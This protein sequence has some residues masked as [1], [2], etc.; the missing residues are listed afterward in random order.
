MDDNI[1]S[2]KRTN[3]NRQINVSDWSMFKAME[4]FCDR[5]TNVAMAWPNY[6]MFI[7]RKQKHPP[8]ICNTRIYSCNL[9]KN[10]VPFRWRG[11]YNEDT[12]LSLDMLKAGFCTVQFNAFLQEK[13]T[14]QTMGGG[15]TEAFYA[16]EWTYLKSK[17]L[18]EAYP[19]YCRLVHKFGRIH[20]TCNYR[21]F[22]NKL[23]FKK[24]VK[25]GN[26]NNEYGFKLRDRE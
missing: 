6:F 5:Y 16:G 17:M 15:N 23:I 9:I 20:H 8:F 4:D 21:V 1:Y 3:K 22:E 18:I 12:I 11:R 14:T 24:D 25:I 13:M 26:G 10:D 2:F 7:P 19:Q